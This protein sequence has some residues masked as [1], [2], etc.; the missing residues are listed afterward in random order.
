MTKEAQIIK[1]LAATMLAQETEAITEA[2]IA[3]IVA[4]FMALYPGAS[5]EREEIIRFL[6]ADFSVVSDIYQILEDANDKHVRWIVEMRANET[7]KWKF[8]HRYELYLKPKMAGPT[9]NQLDNLTTDILDRL[10]SPKTP[11][12]W[13]R[14]GMVVGQ[15]Q[16]GK[17]SNYIGL[18][19]KAA[20]AG[21]KFIIVLAGLHD[22]LRTQTQIRVDAG[23][24]GFNTQ[25]TMNFATANNKIGV[26]KFNNNLAANAL[27]TSNYD[28]DFSRPAARRSGLNI[29]GTDPVILVIKK[30]TSI[31]RNLIQWV[32][33]Q[34]ET[35]ADGKKLVENIPMLLIDDEADNASINVSRNGISTTNGLIR[36]L[37]ALFEQSAY[38][39]YTATPFANIFVPMLDEETAKGLNV[40]VKDFE[41]KVGQDL[42]PRDFIINIP[43]PSNYIGPTRMFG[44]PATAESES[45]EEPLPLVVS[46]S[47]PEQFADDYK[48]FV[49]DKH[50]KDDPLPDRLP[51]SLLYAVKCFIL[52]CAAR[53]ARG[54]VNQHNSMLIHVSRFV[55]WQDRIS[56]LVHD[57]LKA[58]RNEIE[59]NQGMIWAE[60]EEIWNKDF[61]PA[62]DEVMALALADAGAFKDPG[63]AKL[64]WEEV[65][66]HLFASTSKIEVRAVHGDK[67]LANLTYHN[68][69]PLDYFQAEQEN[70]PRFISIIAVG[71]DK[72]SRGLTLEGLSVSYY[73]RA[74]KM[75]DTLMQ[76]GRWFGYR[77]GYADLCR[78][79]TS[80]ELIRWYEHITIASEEVR[81]EFDR[82]FLLGRTPRD[83]GLKIRTHSGVLTIT[84]LNKF[85]YHRIEKLSYSAEL[86][87]TYRFKIN[88]GVF[89]NN[90]K[91]LENLLAQ[92][93][94]PT[95]TSAGKNN[96]VWKTDSQPVK[97]F[98]TDYSIGREVIDTAK[99]VD[100]IDKQ[101]PKGSLVN[102]TVVLI[103]S[104]SANS[105]S[106][107]FTVDGK[108]VKIGL[109]RRKNSA[110]NNEWQQTYAI[111]K[112]QIISPQDEMI[113]LTREQ[114]KKAE[115][116]TQ[117]DWIK[118]ERKGTPSYPST[119]RI[120]DNRSATNGLLLIYPL[121]PEVEYSETSKNN[122][123]KK[124]QTIT[125]VPIVGF[126]ISFPNIENDQKVEYAVNEQF[127][128]EYD[129]DEIFD[130]EDDE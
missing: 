74:S 62:T 118:K 120:K 91:V 77:P 27:T 29:K 107:L 11:G 20:D 4:P 100:Y 82:M 22:S 56:S 46:L 73:L 5:G 68:I 51:P 32:A 39:G 13:D 93:G 108:H 49:P 129:Y 18:I 9:L 63:I 38:V 26:G 24:L 53:R 19:N 98:L 92:L 43:A 65:A 86:K 109:T 81:A 128:S 97:Q 2:R 57:A 3:A 90:H 45:G 83:F 80:G 116:E 64:R 42:F 121:D 130:Q 55:F 33:G 66:E 71:G 112:A 59:F 61:R 6:L 89:R 36:S 69:S 54:Q 7:L 103:N 30:N 12:P 113:D 1:D 96:L 25:T 117:Q 72:L 95:D 34:G 31:L 41:F 47:D 99:M 60:L 16:S 115:E 106:W 40:R 44:L 28:G 102:W 23:F 126:A 35:Q 52:T 101:L 10:S 78:L 50:K 84:A 8:W 124:I 17:T 122:Q 15:V 58:F 14:R 114:V 70:P 125:K 123:G 79:F 105:H 76:M 110:K 21:Y 127:I 94:T 48:T 119:F 67:K 104:G 37:L 88:G 87:Q 75:Y 85:R 111:S